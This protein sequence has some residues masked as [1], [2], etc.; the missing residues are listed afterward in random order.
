MLHRAVDEVILV[1]F[2]GELVVKFAAEGKY[3]HR[4]FFDAWNVFDFLIVVVGLMPFAGSAV[5]ALRL[6]R[7]LRVLKLVR[8]LPKLRILVM[9]LLKSMSSI[10][11]IGLLLM[12]LF[13]LF[14]VSGVDF[15]GKNDPVHFS[16]L[17][18]ALITLF[19]SATLEDW[20]DVMYINIFGCDNYGYD[21]DEL[22]ELVRRNVGVAHRCCITN[23]TMRRDR[24][25][26][27]GSR[28][29][30]LCSP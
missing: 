7:L 30:T 12:L 3:P 22:M 16:S 28:H 19:R 2:I 15:F 21:S 6:V 26:C 13:Y 10:A 17:H 18:V 24:S 4:F 9:G 25:A 20:T 8:A 27:P 23:T 29:K 11:Y 5:T 1:I 14:A